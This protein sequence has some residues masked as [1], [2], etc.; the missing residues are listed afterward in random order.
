MLFTQFNLEDARKVWHREDVE[1]GQVLKLIE[2]VQRKLQKGKSAADIAED[3]DEPLKMV[4]L[5]CSAVS[6]SVP[7]AS[8]ADI[9]NQI[10]DKI[11][12]L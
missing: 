12:L 4:E 2:L 9:Y 8:T 1:E 3:L 6:Q 10:E 5:I 11:S 7:E